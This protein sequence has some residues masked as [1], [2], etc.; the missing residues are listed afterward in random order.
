LRLIYLKLSS[1]FPNFYFLFFAN[2]KHKNL[3]IL[4][5]SSHFTHFRVSAITPLAFKTITTRG[6]YRGAENT[7]TPRRRQSVRITVHCLAIRHQENNKAKSKLQRL[8]R[9]TDCVGYDI[10]KISRDVNH[11]A[12]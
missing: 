9:K 12:L 3:E 11:S 7:A 10:D 5:S 2:N 1:T 6:H 8:T 4:R